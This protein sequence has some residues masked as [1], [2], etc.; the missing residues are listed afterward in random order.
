MEEAAFR[1]ILK[2]SEGKERVRMASLGFRVSQVVLCLVSLSVMAA[3]RTRGWTG[4]SFYRYR[5][6]RHVLVTLF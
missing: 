1:R 2:R 6:Y 4:D 5:E 3:D